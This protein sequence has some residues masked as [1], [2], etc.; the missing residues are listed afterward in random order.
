VQPIK[1]TTS[2]LLRMRKLATARLSSVSPIRPRLTSRSVAPQSPRQGCL[3][4]VHV[5]RIGETSAGREEDAVVWLRRSI[6]A[7]RKYPRSHFILGTSLAAVPRSR[8]RYR[9]SAACGWS[10]CIPIAP[11]R[12]CG[13][14][15]GASGSRI[16]DFRLA[17]RND[18]LTFDKRH[19]IGCDDLPLW[20]DSARSLHRLAMTAMCANATHVSGWSRR[21]PDKRNDKIAAAHAAWYSARV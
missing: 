9:P 14:A 1:A 16:R 3:P 12:A 18:R 8:E 21:N 15:R 11:F 13:R 19:R 4:L 20:V 2:W 17:I 5:R 6:E 10:N 7:D